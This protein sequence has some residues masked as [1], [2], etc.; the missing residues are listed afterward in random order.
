VFFINVPLAAEVIAISLW[1]IPESRNATARHV[2][3]IGALVATTGLG[4]V[5]Y[6][7][8]ESS[9]LGWGR[10]LVFGSLIAGLV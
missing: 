1:H 5:V 2:D 3:W 6:G 10:L 7:L 4:G 9:S 8:I